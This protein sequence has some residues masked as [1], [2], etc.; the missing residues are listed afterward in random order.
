M[1]HTL[2]GIR[3]AVEDNNGESLLFSMRELCD[4]CDVQKCSS[5]NLLK[6]SAELTRHGLVHYPQTLPNDRHLQVRIFFDPNSAFARGNELTPDTSGQSKS[7]YSNEQ[8]GGNYAWVPV[9]AAPKPTP[10]KM[11][12]EERFGEKWNDFGL[13]P[14]DIEYAL[15]QLDNA[16]S[17]V[18]YNVVHSRLHPHSEVAKD[19]YLKNVERV[20]ACEQRVWEVSEGQGL[21]KG[22]MFIYFNAPGVPAE[23]IGKPEEGTGVINGYVMGGFG[24]SKIGAGIKLPLNLNDRPKAKR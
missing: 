17:S 5:G 2:Q 3:Q 8:V 10:V 13:P 20:Y 6:I 14:T 9:K 24:K 11:S 23:L 15:A 21:P 19:S 12:S 16:K 7:S 22:F 18:S 4:A 1:Y